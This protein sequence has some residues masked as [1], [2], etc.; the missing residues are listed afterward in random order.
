MKLWNLCAR[1]TSLLL[2]L[3]SF[4]WALQDGLK[5]DWW[6]RSLLLLLCG[7]AALYVTLIFCSRISAGVGSAAVL[8]FALWLEA[9]CRRP[10]ILELQRIR[11]HVIPLVNQY[12]RTNYD[13]GE[14]AAGGGSGV[15]LLFCALLLGVAFGIP[16]AIKRWR[17]LFAVPLLLAFVCGPLV[18]FAPGLGAMAALVGGLGMQ[19]IIWKEEK[20]A[21][22]RRARTLC[23]LLLL[24]VSL[25][26]ALAAGPLMER[27]VVYHQPLKQYQLS[28]EDK[29]LQSLDQSSVWDRFLWRT[30]QYQQ[31]SAL[32]NQPPDLTDAVIFE[33]TSQSLPTAPVYLKNF[34]GSIYDQ[35]IWSDPLQEAFS[36]F[37]RSQGREAEDYG[38]EVFGQWYRT[39][40]AKGE[41]PQQFTIRIHRH[42]GSFSPVPYCSELPA[43]AAVVGDSGIRM[44]EDTYQCQGYFVSTGQYHTNVVETEIEYR[45][46][47]ENATGDIA[48]DAAGAADA[49]ASDPVLGLEQAYSN[50]VADTYILLPKG[51]L[52]RLREQPDEAWENLA[53]CRYSMELFPAVA[54]WD[55]T[56]YFVLIQQKGYCMHFASAYTLL[57][58]ISRIPA[59]YAGGYLVFPQDFVQNRDGTYTAQVTGKRAHAWMEYYS[60]QKGWFP[61][62]VTPGTGDLL[63]AIQDAQARTDGQRA[64]PDPTVSEPE[65]EIPAGQ[66]QDEMAE[67]QK[68]QEEEQNKT[69]QDPKKSPSEQI[70]GQE[71]EQTPQSAAGGTGTSSKEPSRIWA[72]LA[73]LWPFVLP[74]LVLSFLWFLNSLRL[75]WLCRFRQQRFR[76][77]DD[78]QK[79]AAVIDEVFRLLKLRGLPYEAETDDLAYAR[80]VNERL[81]CFGQAAF[82]QW[83]EAARC[84]RYGGAAM[85]P[86]QM[87]CLF[88]LYEILFYDTKKELKWY[89][90]LWHI[91]VTGILA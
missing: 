29:L 17:V 2:L 51:Q 38:G 40:Q 55:L 10:M 83:M 67:T 50:Y 59:R 35:G 49:L 73:A 64:Q 33:F 15:F 91:Y 23:A 77:P 28:M 88:D 3:L 72:A 30:G 52:S 87:K 39:R 18:G 37:A 24:F 84:A 53:N 48:L 20:S 74:L 45:P 44:E 42:T 8:V 1:F 62:E 16:I 27:L 14:A 68:Q 36:S 63:R 66:N 76:D 32:T 5:I 78:R 26:S 60:P 89:Q 90:R 47:A 58:R 21:G 65:A 70:G 46:N 54:G 43:G 6:D 75:L 71:Q 82:I 19:L 4:F 9:V 57:N 80:I 12:Y 81:A 56:E 31:S 86:E 11:H 34:I 22:E 79:A 13:E 7:G 61:V 25:V 41:E 85:Q 69:E